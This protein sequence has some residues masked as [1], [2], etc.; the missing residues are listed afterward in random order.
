M[1][2]VG[3]ARAEPSYR[4]LAPPWNPGAAY[5]ELVELPAA[6]PEGRPAGLELLAN[7]ADLVGERGVLL[8]HAHQVADLGRRLVERVGGQDDL[9]Q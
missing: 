5:P 7:G 9:E 6:V 1:I 4:G 8:R 3:L 2:R